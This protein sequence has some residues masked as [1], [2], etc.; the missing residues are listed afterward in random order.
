MFDA[1]ILGEMEG[2]HT[3]RDC[4]KDIPWLFFCMNRIGRACRLLA[5]DSGKRNVQTLHLAFGSME[6]L[7]TMRIWFARF[8]GLAALFLLAFIDNI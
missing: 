4:G 6:C 2:Q 5:S 1:E 3:A 8:I 7:P